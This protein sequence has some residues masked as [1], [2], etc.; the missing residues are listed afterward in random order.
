MTNPTGYDAFRYYKSTW[1]HFNRPSFSIEKYGFNSKSVSEGVYRG[2]EN[3]RALYERLAK[4]FTT[5]A[6]L[7]RYIACQLYWNPSYHISNIHI[8]D[9]EP[10]ASRWILMKKFLSATDYYVKGDIKEVL[11]NSKNVNDALYGS[12]TELPNFF[13]MIMNEKKTACYTAAL[14]ISCLGWDTEV[15]KNA[16]SNIV[17]EMTRDRLKG[18]VP[19]VL[20]RNSTK[21][22]SVKKTM[23]DTIDYAENTHQTASNSI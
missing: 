21:Y 7:S 15:D 22:Q 23:I 16:G 2:E 8:K 6:D 12:F 1:L 18:L 13:D 17:W 3:V 11:E 5:R 4:D 20:P 10:M 9:A 19:F 14:M